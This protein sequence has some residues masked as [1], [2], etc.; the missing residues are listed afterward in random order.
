MPSTCNN[1][2]FRC[3]RHLLDSTG[4]PLR[5]ANSYSDIYHI[6][7]RLIKKFTDVAHFFLQHL[8]YIDLAVPTII[9]SMEKEKNVVNLTGHMCWNYTFR[10]NPWI[11]IQEQHFNSMYFHPTK[12]NYINKGSQNH[13]AFFCKMVHHIYGK[14]YRIAVN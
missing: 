7:L 3:Y 6:P 12:W 11:Y 2:M 8:I 10:H 5:I 9:M 14:I 4:S 13:T 1:C